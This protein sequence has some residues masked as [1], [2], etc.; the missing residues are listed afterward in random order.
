MGQ[1]ILVMADKKVFMASV[2]TVGNDG[3]HLCIC[4][5]FMRFDKGGHFMTFIDDGGSD[6][7]GS[8]HFMKR[9]ND[10][11]SFIPELGLC[12]SIT[13]YRRIG[14]RGGDITAVHSF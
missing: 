7:Y 11:V 12:L 2:L 3:T 6:V 13:E 14:V 5:R 10:P 8:D 9:V 1:Y 4:I